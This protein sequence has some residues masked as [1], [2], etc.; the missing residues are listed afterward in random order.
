MNVHKKSFACVTIVAVA[1][2]L[3]G[4][5]TE[6]P[7]STDYKFELVGTPTIVDHRTTISI[8]LVHMDESPV[9]VSQVYVEYWVYNGPKNAP[10]HLERQE[11]QTSAPGMFVYRSNNLHVGETVH[12]VARVAPNSTPIHGSVTIP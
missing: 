5:Q 11:L 4:C 1:V 8:R 10:N 3:A 6:P 12:L 9:A 2:A 7:Q